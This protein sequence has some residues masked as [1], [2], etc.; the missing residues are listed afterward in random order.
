MSRMLRKRRD[1]KDDID[2]DTV[3]RPFTPG[4]PYREGDLSTTT[5]PPP[6]PQ[7]EIPPMRLVAR[8]K[9]LPRSPR[10]TWYSTSTIPAK[11][12]QQPDR[13]SVATIRP[14][15]AAPPQLPQLTINPPSPPGQHTPLLHVASVSPRSSAMLTP[16]PLPEKGSFMP[17]P[18]RGKAPE[19]QD[20][21]PRP[22][23][24]SHTPRASLRASFLSAASLRMPVPQM[25]AAIRS[26][27]QHTDAGPAQ[28]GPSSARKGKAAEAASEAR[29]QSSGD[30]PPPAY[31]E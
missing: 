31:S 29:A 21:A 25:P 18:R 10:A 1:N 24:R 3:P 2:I 9:P 28:A 8:L 15:G 17:R 16:P 5:I 30:M 22:V 6:P 14:P 27:V 4:L 26:V 12:T 7:K 23:S 11:P 19:Q 13:S 20:G